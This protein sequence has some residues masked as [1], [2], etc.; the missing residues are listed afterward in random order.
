MHT[1]VKAWREEQQMKVEG[2]HEGE[3]EHVGKDEDADG[4]DNGTG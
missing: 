2:Q 1:V 3:D 4:Y